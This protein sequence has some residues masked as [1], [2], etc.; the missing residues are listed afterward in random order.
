MCKWRQEADSVWR[1]LAPIAILLFSAE[2]SARAEGMADDA[3]AQ[4]RAV[5][6]AVRINGGEQQPESQLLQLADGGL[7]VAESDLRAWNLR[8]PGEAFQLGGQRYFP[9]S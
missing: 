7:A 8:P 2:L 6:L 1:W 3:G 5:V 4:P 9:L